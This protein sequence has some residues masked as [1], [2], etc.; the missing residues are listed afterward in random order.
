MA[1]PGDGRTD[2]DEKTAPSSYIGIGFADET[3]IVSLPSG[4]SVNN[5]TLDG[6]IDA[7]Y[8]HAREHIDIIT[9][10]KPKPE[11]MTDFARVRLEGV[12]ELTPDEEQRIREAYDKKDFA[13]QYPF[14]VRRV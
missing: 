6:V 10:T 13:K 3:N 12:R 9:G 8:E 14:P 5:S 1:E 11:K 2:A 7:L 4:F